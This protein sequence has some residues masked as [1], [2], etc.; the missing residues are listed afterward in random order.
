MMMMMMMMMMS[1]LLHDGMPMMPMMWVMKMLTYR[2]VRVVHDDGVEGGGDDDDGGDG[3]IDRS[4]E[5]FPLR[6]VG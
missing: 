6:I 2:Y 5:R 1:T 3:S 4:I